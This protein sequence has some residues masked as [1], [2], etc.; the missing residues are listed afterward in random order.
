MAMVPFNRP[1]VGPRCAEL[2]QQ[3]A[4]S[5]HHSGDGPLGRE[6]EERLAA[7]VG[8]ARVVLTPSCTHA[9]EMAALVL[10]IGPDDEVIV[11]SFT[12][13]STATAF[14]LRGARLRFA[15][16]DP[17][18]FDIDPASVANL[19]SDRT[20]A[21]V[22]VHYAGVGCDMAA[23]EK[24]TAPVGASVVEDD[25]HGLFGTLHGRPLGTFGRLATL[26]FHETKNVS[27]GEGGALVVNDDALLDD[28]LIAREK[29]TNRHAFFRRLVDKYTWVGPG[30]SWLP[31]EFTAAVLL[32][33]LDAAP[34]T[35]A[36]RQAI[37]ARYREALGPWAAARGVVFPDVPDG[38]VH[39]AH[40]F[41]MLLPD[42]AAR[43]RF[44]DHMAAHGVQVVFHYL[45]LHSAPAA[46][47]FGAGDECPVAA[48]VSAR[49]VR[50]PLYQNLRD[51]EVDLVIDAAQ[52][53]DG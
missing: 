35:Q 37:W 48:S 25:A 33:G 12:F 45:P 17:T 41:A 31:S 2:L 7:L 53:F 11:P 3:V 28:V 6:C 21:V 34:V 1:Y 14:A 36:R 15:D 19:V 40:L 43:P 50:L 46:A 49:L 22:A 10:D 51:D 23:L 42:A 52:R 32:A 8:D 38:A 20:A 44:I 18:T 5:T 26:S 16:I 4:D 30:S 39:P 47:R 9:L 27:C 24:L 29:G 13:T